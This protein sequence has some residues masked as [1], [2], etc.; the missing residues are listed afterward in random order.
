M[1][2]WEDLRGG[3]RVWHPVLGPRPLCLRPLPAS[4]YRLLERNKEAP[5]PGSPRQ[6]S[7]QRLL[8][9]TFDLGLECFEVLPGPKA[10]FY[11]KGG[12]GLAGIP[13]AALGCWRHPFL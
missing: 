1:R 9:P 3:P 7:L 6:E 13:Q 10:L 11:C 5:P 12:A 4:V 2:S 8:S